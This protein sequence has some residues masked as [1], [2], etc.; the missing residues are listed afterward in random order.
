MMDIINISAH[1]YMPGDMIEY[2]AFQGCY[3][4]IC[5]GDYPLKEL[6][7]SIY[8][9]EVLE[10]FIV[11]ELDFICRNSNIEIEIGQTSMEDVMEPYFK[12]ISKIALTMIEERI[13][14][15][16][17]NNSLR[18]FPKKLCRPD[19]IDFF[20]VFNSVYYN[21]GRGWEDMYDSYVLEAKFLG[22]LD[23]DGPEFKKCIIPFKS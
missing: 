3:S 1:R 9:Y 15:H 13:A 22:V 21:E 12:D 18:M 5:D 16:E 17:K 11:F 2:D 7:G 23:I 6:E 14:K 19:H 8:K 20:I 4:D 10:K